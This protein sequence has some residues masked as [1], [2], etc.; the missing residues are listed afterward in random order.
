[1]IE[2][3]LLFRDFEKKL[4]GLK[5]LLS[6]STEVT[7]ASNVELTTTT[8]ATTAT[9][10]TA[11]TTTARIISSQQKTV[12]CNFCRLEHVEKIPP[13]FELFSTFLQRPT[14]LHNLLI[15]IPSLSLSLDS[16]KIN[17]NISSNVCIVFVQ[18]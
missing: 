2:A 16:W 18:R 4:N 11:T 7:K 5:Y 8:T 3:L 13:R 14:F 12:F 1:M 17:Q 15:Q 9:T 6:I 10:T